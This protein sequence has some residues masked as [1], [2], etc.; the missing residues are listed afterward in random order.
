[1]RSIRAGTHRFPNYKYALQTETTYPSVQAFL[2][3][4]FLKLGKNM[5]TFYV[6][7]VLGTGSDGTVYEVQGYQ[8]RGHFALKILSL[9]T[10]ARHEIERQVKL[11]R[12]VQGPYVIAI[13]DVL[14]TS[15]HAYILFECGKKRNLE[16]QLC[17]D[18]AR[19]TP[20]DLNCIWSFFY[21]MV[22]AV[23]H[24][25]AN[26]I[27]HGDIKPDNFVFSKQSDNRLT[28]QDDLDL[29]LTDFSMAFESQNAKPS[30][31]TITHMAP[32]QL[33]GQSPSF[34]TD[35]WSLGIS[36]FRM[37]VGI[38]PYYDDTPEQMARR[39]LQHRPQFTQQDLQQVLQFRGVS[40]AQQ[41]LILD[42][43][44]SL[45]AVLPWERIDA[46]T[47]LTRY[48]KTLFTM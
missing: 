21:E 24:C 17:D 44:D 8:H 1:M 48:P 7:R 45:L 14:Y 3:G 23:A 28:I 35:M 32:E 33:R 39:L 4:Q 36:L 29:K 16:L 6:E 46:K 9:K 47:L 41:E 10:H 30:L 31:T 20:V 40:L 13:Y 26:N 22:Q 12:R 15:E 5:G 43:M 18:A 38:E 42:L 34:A 27:V 37:L 2:P 19:A 11:Q 25:H